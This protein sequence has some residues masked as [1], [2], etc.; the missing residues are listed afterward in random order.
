MHTIALASVLP[1]QHSWHA[2]GMEAA[3]GGYRFI[4]FTWLGMKFRESNKNL[5]GCFR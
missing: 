4:Q 5:Q 3:K 1:T 2:Y